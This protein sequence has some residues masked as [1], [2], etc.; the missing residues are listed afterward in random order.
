MPV[1]PLQRTEAKAANSSGFDFHMGD[2]VRIRE[3]LESI[4]EGEAL[5]DGR[6]QKIGMHRKKARDPG[7]PVGQEALPVPVTDLPPERQHDGQEKQG[8]DKRPAARLI[9]KR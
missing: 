6:I 7:A 9:L 5:L 2:D 1:V 4:E 8:N 3:G